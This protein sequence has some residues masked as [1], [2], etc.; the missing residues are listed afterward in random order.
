MKDKIS[1]I[2]KFPGQEIALK[3]YAFA[4]GIILTTMIYG[5]NSYQR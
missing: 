4:M 1:R 3:V 5:E 2:L